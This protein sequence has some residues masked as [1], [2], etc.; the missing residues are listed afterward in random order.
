MSS[1]TRSRRALLLLLLLLVLLLLVLLLVEVDLIVGA[2]V[3]LRVGALVDLMLDVLVDLVLLDLVDLMLL[4]L[5]DF[6]ES[7]RAIKGS[8][9]SVPS[10]L[11]SPRSAESKKRIKTLVNFIVTIGCW[12]LL[13]QNAI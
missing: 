11:T 8:S 5:V 12:F 13:Y 4:D 7:R 9:N 1:I 3:D 10:A 6:V 2:L